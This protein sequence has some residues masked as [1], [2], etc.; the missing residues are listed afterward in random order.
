MCDCVCVYV[1]VQR[2]IGVIWCARNAQFSMGRESQVHAECDTRAGYVCVGRGGEEEKLHAG[3]DDEIIC[4]KCVPN[5]RHYSS[6]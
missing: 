2:V 6:C 5:A 1:Y 3:R 4:K